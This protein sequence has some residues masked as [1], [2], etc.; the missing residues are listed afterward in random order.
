MAST[1]NI[2]NPNDYAMRQRLYSGA[3]E[4]LAFTPFHVAQNTSLPDL[5][6]PSFMP[7]H[8]LCSNS[9]DVESQLFGINASNLVTPAQK[10]TPEIKELP[11]VSFFERQLCYMPRNLTVEPNQRPFF[12]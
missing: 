11:S 4:Y 9:I 6:A 10:V 3:S 7:R 2:N 5:Y 1:R 8:L 12:W